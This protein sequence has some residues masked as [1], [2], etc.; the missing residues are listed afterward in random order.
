MQVPVDHIKI[1]SEII[2]TI[3]PAYT[4]DRVNRRI[5]MQVKDFAPGDSRIYYIDFERPRV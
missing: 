1:T 3:I 4:Y 5:L 2:G